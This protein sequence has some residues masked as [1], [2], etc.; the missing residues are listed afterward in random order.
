MPWDSLLVPTSL[1]VG[2]ALRSSRALFSEFLE[3][4]MQKKPLASVIT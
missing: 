1:M 2:L 4:P 3:A